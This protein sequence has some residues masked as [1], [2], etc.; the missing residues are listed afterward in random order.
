MLHAVRIKITRR[1]GT[2][3]MLTNASLRLELGCSRA[4]NTMVF[5]KERQRPPT[6][7]IQDNTPAEPSILV[8]QGCQIPP[9]SGPKMF[10][11]AS[12]G[13][14][15]YGLRSCQ[16]F[17]GVKYISD[18]PPF[19]GSQKLQAMARYFQILDGRNKQITEGAFTSIQREECY[20]VGGKRSRV[21]YSGY[22][23]C[24]NTGPTSRY[25]L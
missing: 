21:C 9:V 4:N 24:A 14:M 22:G 12:E 5:S 13:M 19:Q 3:H 16:C 2:R 25:T 15:I 7:Q 20:R 10:M 1:N 18:R 23:A 6:G 11:I 8:S 17:A